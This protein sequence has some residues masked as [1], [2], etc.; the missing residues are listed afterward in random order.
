MPLYGNNDVASN[1]PLWILNQL[2]Q[3]YSA[4]NVNAAYGNVVSGIYTTNATKGVFAVSSR[5]QSVLNGNNQINLPANAAPAHSG[6]VLRTVGSGG[7]A[8]R[9]HYEVLVANR[10]INGD[11]ADNNIFPNTRIGVTGPS[12]SN[13]ARGNV[14]NFVISSG[15]EPGG[16]SLTYQWQQDNGNVAQTWANVAN[17]GVFA[18]ANSNTTTTLSISN[19]F[20][21]TGNTFRVAVSTAFG[22]TVFSSNAVLSYF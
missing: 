3:G 14:V 21:V 20:T 4:N 8:G 10:S 18:S 11:G 17:A 12:S 19:N 2:G 15:S 16:Q 22:N 7:R 5:E 9:V 1:T 6:W 13:L